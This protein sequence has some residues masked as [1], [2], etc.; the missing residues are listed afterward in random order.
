MALSVVLTRL[1][2]IFPRG[3]FIQWDLVNPTESGSYSFD[4]YRSGGPE[5]PW[6]PLSLGGV[7]IFNYKDTIPTVTASQA[8][9]TINELSITRGIFYRVVVTPPSGVDGQVEVVS[10]VEPR[11]DGKQRLLKQKILRDES[12]AFKKLNGVELAVCKRMHWGTRCTKCWDKTTK[13]VIRS[14]CVTCMGT[15]FEPGYFTP[16]LTLGRRGVIPASKQITP[17]GISEFRPTQVTILDAPKVEPDDIIVFLRDN[18]RF[19]VKAVVQTELRTV[20]V[21]QKFE[22]SEI[23]RSAIEYRLVVDPARLPPLF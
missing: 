21:H 7:D 16:V 19:V 9:E 2:P 6:E 17:Q 4:I 22:V 13:Q 5:G 18:R 12:L 15:G 11:L 20:G 23:A 14:N 8:T 10:I 1:L 3:I